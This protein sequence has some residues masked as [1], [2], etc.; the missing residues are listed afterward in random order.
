M[1][2]ECKLCGSFFKSNNKQRLYCDDC[3]KNTETKKRQL[4]RAYRESKERLDDRKTYD[5]DCDQCG[6]TFLAVRGLEHR[7]QGNIFCSSACKG[8]WIKDHTTCIRCGKILSDSTYYDPNI[9][10]SAFCD[11]E[12]H[13]KYLYEEAKKRGDVKN[14]QQCG[15]E[16]V[17]KNK[18]FC[19][20][21][22]MEKAKASDWRPYC[23]EPVVRDPDF[24]PEPK[25]I[26]RR[27]KCVGCK[28]ERTRTYT[29]P[30]PDSLPLW[31]C[32]KECKERYLAAIKAEKKSFNRYLKRIGKTKEE[33]MEAQKGTQ[34][35]QKPTQKE[36]ICA[37]CKTS[38]ADCERMQSDFRVLPKGAHYNNQGVLVECPKFS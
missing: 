24:V 15:K 16:Y 29:L 12:C 9:W 34:K 1:E 38:Y 7:K 31:A 18:Y 35:P 26:Q 23:G 11:K 30:L 5:Y 22:C 3:Q 8:Q 28:R 19:S 13:D 32:S 20:K 4:T 37:I 33:Y 2:K 10:Q 27:E 14:C 21:E 17:S 25:T 36:H 6:K